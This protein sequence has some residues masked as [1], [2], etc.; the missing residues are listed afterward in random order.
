MVMEVAKKISESIN[1]FYCNCSR[2]NHFINLLLDDPRIIYMTTN[3]KVIELLSIEHQPR[4][5]CVGWTEEDR[6]RSSDRS[7]D[8]WEENFSDFEVCHGM[9]AKRINEYNGK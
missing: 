3:K 5:G 1:M 2:K 8:V 6:C 7:K 4:K 9:P